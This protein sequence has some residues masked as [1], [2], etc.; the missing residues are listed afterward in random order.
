MIKEYITQKL[1][2]IGNKLKR[3]ITYKVN[4]KLIEREYQ[5]IPIR[6]IL[7]ILITVLEVAT[8][9]GIVISLC[10]F[11]PFFYLTAMVTQ[12]GCVLKIISSDDNPD[13]KV[14]WLLF[15][16][17]LP[18][19]G[20]MLY[21]I[22]SSRKLKKKFVKRLEDLNNKTYEKQDEKEFETLKSENL[23]A[24]SQAKMLTKTAKTH[25]FTNVLQK[26][27]SSGEEMFLGILEDLKNARKFIYL[28]YFII[29][30]GRFW[31]SIF[32]I[33]QEKVNDGVEVK[34]IYDDIGCMKTLP[35]DYYKILRKVGIQATCFSRLRGAA[36]SEFNNRN[37][38]KLLIIDGYIG[39]TGGVNIA[40]E[41]INEVERFGYWKD[42][43]IRL[44]GQAVWELTKLFVID[45]G[46]NVKQIP[47]T[48]NLLYPNCERSFQGYLVPFGD[49]PKPLYERGVGKGIIQS[50]LG[51]AT[52]SVCITT[53]YLIID[54]DLCQSLEDAALR[55]VDVKIVLPRI[56]DKKIIFAIS[57]S[58]YKRLMDAGVKIYEYE[59]GFIHSKM[60]LVDGDT[61]MVGTINMDYRSLT[62]HFE[63]GVWLYKCDCI[64]NMNQDFLEILDS[65][66]LMDEESIKL[67][68]F[69]RFLRAVVRIFAPLF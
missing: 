37:H 9:I 36:D 65:S 15:V 3:K 4:N 13:Y 14:P 6:Y 50:M 16:L 26:Y 22:F 66:L 31:N 35:G 34:V 32:Q 42:C 24:Y 62:H 7:A 58:F 19:A 25:L 46:I 17:I 61:A 48:E 23:T 12:I 11:I 30:Q 51:S 43:G 69:K 29:E 49:G 55:G 59:P 1:V 63:N 21:F 41:Y 54:N 2:L 68:P 27:Y 64:N 33:L 67:S 60:Y 39:W 8:I 56:P 18:I 45:F 44:E 53:P 5:Y 47:L 52:K 20:F 57:R 10:Y 40:D 38:R 28:E